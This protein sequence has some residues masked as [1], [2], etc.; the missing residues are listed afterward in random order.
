MF[1]EE[2]MT[3]NKAQMRWF[4][5]VDYLIAMYDMKAL[6]FL[7]HYPS[8]KVVREGKRTRGFVNELQA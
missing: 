7:E 3:R 4:V 1:E 6:W 8:F 2:K 5:H